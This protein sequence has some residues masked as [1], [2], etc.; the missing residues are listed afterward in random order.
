METTALDSDP[1]GFEITASAGC[2]TPKAVITSKDKE[3]SFHLTLPRFEF[4]SRVADGAMP[5]SFS[6]ECCSDF[7]SLKP[8]CMRKIGI[9][10]NAR[11]MYLIEVHTSGT[12]QRQAIHLL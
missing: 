3:F 5:S 1:P 12:I 11:V 7:M 6:R 9:K 8:R 10:S 4:L 2:E